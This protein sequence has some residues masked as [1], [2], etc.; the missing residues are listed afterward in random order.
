[1]WQINIERIESIVNKANGYTIGAH[2]HENALYF[3][4][5]NH[6]NNQKSM[7]LSKVKQKF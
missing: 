3:P 1:M 6:K 5:N 7:W 4:T 2:H